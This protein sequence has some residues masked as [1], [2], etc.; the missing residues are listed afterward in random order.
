MV[1]LGDDLSADAHDKDNES[2][3]MNDYGEGDEEDEEKRIGYCSSKV[4]ELVV[5]FE[6]SK[7]LSSNHEFE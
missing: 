2:I 5:P 3:I 4:E 7:Q 1:Q 6:E